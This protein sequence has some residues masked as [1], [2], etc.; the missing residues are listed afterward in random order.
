MQGRVE[1]VSLGLPWQQ[2]TGRAQAAHSHPRRRATARQGPAAAAGAGAGTPAAAR[3]APGLTCTT[4]CSGVP[5]GRPSMTMLLPS[6]RYCTPTGRLE[7]ASNA[8][9]E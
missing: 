9:T 2:G 7:Y 5:A 4:I 6:V 8:V 1:R 3:R